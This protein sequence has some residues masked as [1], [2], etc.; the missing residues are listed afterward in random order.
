[1]RPSPSI[2]PDADD[3]DIFLVFNDYGRC[4]RAWCETGEERTDRET[5]IVELMEGQFSSP[6]RVIA[7]NIAEGWSRDVSTEIADEIARRC[8]LDGL[9]VPPLL[10][11]FVD[12]HNTMQPTQLRLPLRGP[13]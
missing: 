5:V 11:S 3:R 4:G 7:F 1:M 9:D 6:V 10:D 8:A 12:R 2:V 13:A